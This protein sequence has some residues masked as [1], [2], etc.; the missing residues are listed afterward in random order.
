MNKEILKNQL[1]FE[2]IA[3]LFFE[4]SEERYPVPDKILQVTS[5]YVDP[6]TKDDYERLIL[7]IALLSAI[8]NM[9]REVSPTRIYRSLQ[10]RDDLFGAIIDALEV[11]EDEIE[12]MEEEFE[13]ELEDESQG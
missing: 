1:D 8:R 7:K 3:A 11:L 12:E 4:I 5:K 9:V 13:D 6:L 10:H 2:K